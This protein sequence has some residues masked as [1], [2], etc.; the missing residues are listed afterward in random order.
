ML[1]PSK[2]AMV[3]RAYRSYTQTGVRMELNPNYF[4]SDAPSLRAIALWAIA[5][6]ATLIHQI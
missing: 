2:G 1:G 4:H 3:D 6:I 5:F